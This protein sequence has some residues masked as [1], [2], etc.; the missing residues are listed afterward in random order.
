M[1]YLYKLTC[2]KLSVTYHYVEYNK[3]KNKIFHTVGMV[4][5]SNKKKMDTPN[6]HVHVHFNQERNT[7]YL[8]VIIKS[9]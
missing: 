6:T 7:L 1:L 2:N 3:R 5:K 4:P 8:M 9:H